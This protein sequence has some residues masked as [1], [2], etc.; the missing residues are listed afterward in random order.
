MTTQTKKELPRLIQLIQKYFWKLVVFNGIVCVIAITVLLLLPA[1]YSSTAII[2]IDK[3]SSQLDMSSIAVGSLGLFGSSLGLSSNDEV[4]RNIRFLNSRTMKDKVIEEFDLMNIWGMKSKSDTYKK[5]SE[6]VFFVDNEDGS[7]SI[8]C[9]YKEDPDKAAEIAN[10][11]VKELSYFINEYEDQYRVFVQDAFNKQTQKMTKVEKEYADFQR[12]TGIYD[13]EKQTELS[14]QALTELEIAKL[15]AEI[16]WELAKNNYSENDPRS[17]NVEREIELYTGKIYEYKNSN[18]YSNIPVDKL[19]EQGI[20][21][22]RLYREYVIQEKILQFLSMEKEQAIL[23]EQ[24]K[25]SNFIIIDNAVPSDKRYKPKR[26]SSLILI[27]LASGL[28]SLTA[29]NIKE[30][31]FN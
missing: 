14:F 31:Y 30:N 11:Y 18:D 27:L 13:L 28:L 20:D 9:N 5:L 25:N 1:W 12:N 6:N 24:K 22:L 7:I 8:S 29:A 10:Y 3:N 4:L 2:M 16:K 23:D 17:K 19:S 15:Q 21:Y 26:T